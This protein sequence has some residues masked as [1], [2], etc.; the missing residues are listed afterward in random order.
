M[1][2]RC[3]ERNEI[4]KTKCCKGHDG[5][6]KN[7]SGG[8][9]RP[10]AKTRR[11]AWKIV[12]FPFIII[13]EGLPISRLLFYCHLYR[14]SWEKAVMNMQLGLLLNIQRLRRN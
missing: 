5:K 12:K 9:G 10:R 13:R 6:R 4:E 3:R 11:L 8:Q 2:N 14:S 1:S 7:G